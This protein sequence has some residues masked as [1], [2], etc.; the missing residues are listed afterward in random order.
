M[1]DS[2]QAGITGR[3]A[4]LLSLFAAYSD[5]CQL[6]HLA[7]R[8]F[9]VGDNALFFPQGRRTDGAGRPLYVAFHDGSSPHYYLDH[10][11]AA[12]PAPSGGAREAH[13]RTAPAA[14]AAQLR[15]LGAGLEAKRPRGDSDAASGAGN[16]PS[17]S[18]SP[19]GTGTPDAGLGRAS[20][21]NSS[22]SGTPRW[23]DF[24]IG[25]VLAIRQLDSASSHQSAATPG[26]ANG[27]HGRPA[28]HVSTRG[29]VHHALPGI[30]GG[31][32]VHLVAVR[33][34]R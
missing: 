16:A 23:P 27:T 18:S 30:P 17:A 19:A 25:E 29:P 5:R 12:P 3:L 8:A 2:V 15:E 31:T 20:S 28:L 22:G 11:A 24:I 7:F 33:W 4:T 13:A 1:S 10:D 32:V 6:S 21:A 9:A 14:V 34:L 26:A